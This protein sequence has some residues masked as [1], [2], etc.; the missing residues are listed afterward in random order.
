MIKKKQN[1]HDK[2]EEKEN[3]EVGGHTSSLDSSAK[4]TNEQT[5]TEKQY[6][7]ENFGARPRKT[8]AK[9]PTPQQ[10]S[11]SK[12]NQ[13]KSQSDTSILSKL[14]EFDLDLFVEIQKIG[15]MQG[16]KLPA[17]NLRG[18]ALRELKEKMFVQL[19]THFDLFNTVEQIHKKL[20]FTTTIEP[21]MALKNGRVIR[22][23]ADKDLDGKIEDRSITRAIIEPWKL[24]E[25]RI[26]IDPHLRKGYQKIAEKMLPF[27]AQKDESCT[28]LSFLLYQQFLYLENLILDRIIQLHWI[29]P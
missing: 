10:T 27:F 9:S 13:I 25:C 2:Q 20:D 21:R 28:L 26:R 16:D 5:E 4:T 19:C 18:R 1:K 11:V 23:F 15:L 3:K 22:Y 29:S 6:Y 14:T 12:I 7:E 24:G 8:Q 17:E